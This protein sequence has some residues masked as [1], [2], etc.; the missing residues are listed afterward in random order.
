MSTCP[1]WHRSAA[2]CPTRQQ[3]TLLLRRTAI[4]LHAS[5]PKAHKSSFGSASERFRWKVGSSWRQ[6]SDDLDD[7]AAVSAVT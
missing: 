6:L 7:V 2:R 4:K 5:L 3:Q 1:A